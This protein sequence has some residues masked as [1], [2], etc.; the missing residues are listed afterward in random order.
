MRQ[1]GE[2]SPVATRIVS[3][4]YLP[5]TVT[6]EIDTMIVSKDAGPGASR[7]GVPL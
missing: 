7:Y 2:S 5:P 6:D 3:G 1:P 4:G